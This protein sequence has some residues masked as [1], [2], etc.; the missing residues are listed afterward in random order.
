[1]GLADM[2]TGWSTR[3]NSPLGEDVTAMAGTDGLQDMSVRSTMRFIDFARS[4][5]SQHVRG[6][7]WS[8][9]E[10]DAVW[11]IGSRS[12]LTLPGVPAHQASIP[13]AFILE[14]DINPCLALP[15]V[16]GQ[17]LTLHVNGRKLGWARVTGPSRVRCRLPPDLLAAGEP[18]DIVLEHPCFVRADL[19]GTSTDDRPL[20]IRFF[21]M[22]LYPEGLAATIDQLMPLR[23]NPTRLDLR[24]AMSGRS[25]GEANL[26]TPSAATAS[27]QTIYEFGPGHASAARL[28]AGWHIDAEGLLWTAATTCDMELPAPAGPGPYGLRIM[29][30]P[31]IVKDLLPTQRLVVIVE[32]LLLG[33]FRLTTETALTMLLPQDLIDGIIEDGAHGGA[34]D[35]AAGRTA[36]LRLTLLVPNALPMRQFAYDHPRH[37]LGMAIDRIVVE[38]VP[39]RLCVAALPRG[40]GLDILPPLAVSDR[41]LDLPA[42]A[43]RDAITA[44]LG[45]SPANLMRGFESLG[46][47]CAFGLAQR[48]AGAEILGL[49]RFANTPLRALLRAMADAFKAAATA[50][51]VELYL[52]A[53]EPREYMMRVQRYGIRWHTMIHEADAEASAVAREQTMKLGFLRRKFL[54]GLRSGRKI[55][56]LV[57]SEPK[58]VAVA[59][60]GWDAPPVLTG[61]LGP[62]QLYPVWDAPQ[63][64]EELPSTL[65]LAEA[66]SVLLDLNRHGSNTL[67]YFVPCT[68]GRRAGTVELLAP[69]LMRAYMS[70]FVILPYGENPNDLDWVRVAANAWLLHRDATA[71]MNLTAAA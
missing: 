41:F 1:M 24:P 49:L 20:A 48:K 54:E 58:K 11:T 70:S 64:Y 56:T 62:L 44:E 52:H 13:G 26:P 35:V 45:T 12:T 17:L 6:E 39:Q 28:G 33:Q 3:L 27:D 14:M 25:A 69:G 10:L 38:R 55:Y 19:L 46:D 63:I 32:G 51:E 53:D 31:L 34:E 29:L 4:G 18:I 59:M 9:Q 36:S 67:I 60:P 23:P 65:Y 37:A 43:L 68:G 2:G 7:G 42:D 16:R 21:G 22:R 61:N 15:A 8:G 71:K 50:S 47:N 66:L 30:A 5:N 57:R 40:D